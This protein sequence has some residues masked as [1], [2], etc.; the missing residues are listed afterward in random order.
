MLQETP[1]YDRL[2]AERGDVPAR[3]RGEADRIHRQ[4]A[5]LLHRQRTTSPGHAPRDAYGPQ[6]R[7]G[8]HATPQRKDAATTS[9]RR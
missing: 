1:A 9:A 5:P 6:D 4:L 3:V 7:P 8:R 2:V